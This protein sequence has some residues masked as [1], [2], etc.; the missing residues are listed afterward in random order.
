MPAALIHALVDQRFI[1]I[2]R[3][4]YLS[5]VPVFIAEQT[6]CNDVMLLGRSS[7]FVGL[8]MLAGALKVLS[9]GKSNLM[10]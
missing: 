7:I 10:L 9:L 3:R 2:G 8:K 1:L 6:S 5:T 4:S